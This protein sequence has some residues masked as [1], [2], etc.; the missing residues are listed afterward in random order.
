L[1]T[2]INEGHPP[3][4]K[5]LNWVLA[6]GKQLHNSHAGSTADLTELGAQPFGESTGPLHLVTRVQGGRPSPPSLTIPAFG[7]KNAKISPVTPRTMAASVSTRSYEDTSPD[8][9]EIVTP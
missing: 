5:E 3:T 9:I 1:L 2:E 4:G 6:A 8:E 7:N